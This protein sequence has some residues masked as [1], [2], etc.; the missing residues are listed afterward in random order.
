MCFSEKRFTSF[1]ALR[2]RGL[3]SIFIS[4]DS[5]SAEQE[6][7]LLLV[8]HLWFAILPTLAI[9]V[10]GI[11]ARYWSFPPERHFS[12]WQNRRS[13]ANRRP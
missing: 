12:V 9:S 8:I 13:P 7:Q 6:L 1:S 4:N 3:G 2:D 5:G 10:V 11:F